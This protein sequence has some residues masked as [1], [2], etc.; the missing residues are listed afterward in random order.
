MTHNINSGSNT[1]ST[2]TSN[3]NNQM[4]QDDILQNTRS[5]IQSLDF[6]WAYRKQRC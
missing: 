1:T 6:I 4:N 2:T 5:V 3:S